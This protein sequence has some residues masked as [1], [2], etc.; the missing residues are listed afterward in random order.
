MVKGKSLNLPTCVT[1]FEFA[2]VRLLIGSLY[3]LNKQG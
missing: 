3:R 2:L 1:D